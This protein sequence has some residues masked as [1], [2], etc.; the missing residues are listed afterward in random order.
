VRLAI[1]WMVVGCIF[2]LVHRRN[3]SGFDVSMAFYTWMVLVGLALLVGQ[4]LPIL[5]GL[6]FLGVTPSSTCSHRPVPSAS[7]Q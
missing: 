5:G 1:A 2:I 4:R 6:I 7:S 3:S